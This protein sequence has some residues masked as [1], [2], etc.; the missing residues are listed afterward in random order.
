M[1]GIGSRARQRYQRY[2]LADKPGLH[3]TLDRL[4]N[5]PRC[6]QGTAGA[7]GICGCGQVVNGAELQ[8]ALG[9]ARL[10]GEC[11]G[12]VQ[13]M[14]VVIKMTKKVDLLRSNAVILNVGSVS[15]KYATG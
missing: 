12:M 7:S 1:A 13:A 11:D 4:P 5:G 3:G 2:L 6:R 9:D 10:G 15:S 8:D 14:T